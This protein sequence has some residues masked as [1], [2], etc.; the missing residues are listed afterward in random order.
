MWRGKQSREKLRKVIADM[1]LKNRRDKFSKE[2][3][4]LGRKSL[5]SIL[6][7]SSSRR[8]FRSNSEASPA[9]DD[10]SSKSGPD[11]HSVLSKIF[12]G[13]K[14]V[15]RSQSGGGSASVS[16]SNSHADSKSPAGSVAKE[17]EEYDYVPTPGEEEEESFSSPPV[18][19]LNFMST[20]P[21]SMQSMET[22]VSEGELGKQ[23]SWLAPLR[24]GFKRPASFRR[25]DSAVSAVSGITQSSWESAVDRNI[26]KQLS[27]EDHIDEHKPFEGGRL[28]E[29]SAS[30]R[31][32]FSLFNK[33]QDSHT[34]WPI[35]E[36]TSSRTLL[37]QRKKDGEAKSSGH[38][39]ELRRSR[40]FNASMPI[41]LAQLQDLS[42]A[43]P[44]NDSGSYGE[45]DEEGENLPRRRSV[46]RHTIAATD[47]SL[48]SPRTPRQ[49]M[50]DVNSHRRATIARMNS[51]DSSNPDSPV[52]SPGSRKQLSSRSLQHNLSA[53][54]IDFTN[55]G[56]S[57]RSIGSG[58]LD[59][60]SPSGTVKSTDISHESLPSVQESQASALVS[61]VSALTSQTLMTKDTGHTS[62][63]MVEEEKMFD[64]SADECHEL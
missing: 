27:K 12:T 15:R 6:R 30:R 59:V 35:H 51:S 10:E 48:F 26:R 47:R 33:R 55:T 23:S 62:V 20:R 50:A 63:S 49:R 41:S 32:I 5:R 2:S 13:K 36:V 21:I 58:R 18:Q 56:Y 60:D 64:I 43:S 24:G 46:K 37:E 4:K 8:S 39:R 31:R 57:S 61:Q 16:L 1:M 25:E 40:T 22:D 28:P 44:S 34:Q 38:D 53:R 29:Q 17:G 7:L 14:K 42:M 9:S 3:K 45:D 11:D 54:S 52:L 19:H